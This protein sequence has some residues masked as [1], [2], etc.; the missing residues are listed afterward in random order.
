M[1][2]SKEILPREVAKKYPE[3]PTL[4]FFILRMKKKKRVW[5]QW[6]M[7]KSWLLESLG[8]SKKLLE[9][10]TAKPTA[11]RGSFGINI[12]RVGD[13]LCLHSLTPTF[14]LDYVEELNGD[15]N[16]IGKISSYISDSQIQEDR[17]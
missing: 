8:D 11:L 17:S 13:L 6:G 12:R 7:N 10:S 2:Y 15:S 9:K 4:F 16:Q 14:G 3:K 1:T 5:A